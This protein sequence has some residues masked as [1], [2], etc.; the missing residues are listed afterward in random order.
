[1]KNEGKDLNSS[2]RHY[3][4]LLYAYSM[5]RPVAKE[6]GEDRAVVSICGASKIDTDTRDIE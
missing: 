1:M 4:L 3:L 5:T 6:L 2:M